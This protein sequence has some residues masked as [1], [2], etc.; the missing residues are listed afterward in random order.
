MAYVAQSH[1]VMPAHLPAEAV[2]E[3]RQW[4]LRNRMLFILAAGLASWGAVIGSGYL[5]VRLVAG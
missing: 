1:R 3:T 4:S 5:L 2:E